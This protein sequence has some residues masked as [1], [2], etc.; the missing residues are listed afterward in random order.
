MKKG[1]VQVTDQTGT[2]KTKTILLLAVLQHC[3]YDIYSDGDG[4]RIP[5]LETLAQG[6]LLHGPFQ[7]SAAR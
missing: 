4:K 7:G 6:I 1:E 2:G 5:K 3:D